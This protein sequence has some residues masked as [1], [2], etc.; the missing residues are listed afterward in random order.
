MSSA[1]SSLGSSRFDCI[2][3]TPPSSVTYD[4]LAALDL[5]SRASTPS[6]V[7]LWVGSGQAGLG[8]VDGGGI[9]L[10][11]GR[12]LLA[13][14]GYRRCEDIVWLKTNRRDPESELVKEVRA[15]PLS[16]IHELCCSASRVGTCPNVPC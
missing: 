5:P 2:L 15:V 8:G 1:L 14:W 12:E 4:E 10:E 13:S 7:W 6:F 9:G 11:Q 3:L 16:L